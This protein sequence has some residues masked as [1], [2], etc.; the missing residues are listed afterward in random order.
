MMSW[1]DMEG[2][3]PMSKLHNRSPVVNPSHRS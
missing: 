2:E 3:L 1:R